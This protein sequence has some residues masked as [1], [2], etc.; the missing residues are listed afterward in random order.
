MS[1]LLASTSRVQG[2][3]IR[4]QALHRKSWAQDTNRQVSKAALC[5]SAPSA[6]GAA[7]HMQHPLLCS[8][9]LCSC[10]H[11]AHAVHCAGFEFRKA[12]LR[13]VALRRKVW[14]LVANCLTCASLYDLSIQQSQ[15]LPRI[16]E[17]SQRC[18]KRMSNPPHPPPLSTSPMG[19]NALADVPARLS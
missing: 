12:F 9:L 3:E 10:E 4:G 8:M 1:Q 6:L 13:N 17:W 5:M 18:T 14:Q 16:P 2:S 11:N 19:K 15:C 7:K